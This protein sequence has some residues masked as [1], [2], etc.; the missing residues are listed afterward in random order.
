M[1]CICSTR[2]LTVSFDAQ[3]IW[4]ACSASCA[5]CST[6]PILACVDALLAIVFH[7]MSR[8]F[9]CCATARADSQ[10]AIASP[11]RFA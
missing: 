3:A 6:R 9:A 5:A 4:C 1:T 2:M 7:S 10:A 11:R 8:R